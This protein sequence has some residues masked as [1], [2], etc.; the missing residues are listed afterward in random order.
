MLTKHERCFGSS[1]SCQ[2]SFRALPGILDQGAQQLTTHL[3]RAVPSIHPY[4]VGIGSSTFSVKGYYSQDN[5]RFVD[6]MLFLHFLYKWYSLY[7]F[8]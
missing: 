7:S 4:A 3:V 2:D 8:I 6:L 1:E 5:K